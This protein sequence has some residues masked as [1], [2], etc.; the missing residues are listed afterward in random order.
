MKSIKRMLT[1]VLALVLLYLYR[2]KIFEPAK[3]INRG[4]SV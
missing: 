2:K 3:K 1:L 4:E